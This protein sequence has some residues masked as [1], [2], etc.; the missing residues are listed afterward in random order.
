MHVFKLISSFAQQLDAYTDGIIMKGDIVLTYTI[1]KIR[2]SRITVS[3]KYQI[4]ISK[5]ITDDVI[6][7]NHTTHSIQFNFIY[8]YYR[9]ID[10]VMRQLNMSKGA[11]SQNNSDNLR[12]LPLAFFARVCVQI[13]IIL[14]KPVQ[15]HGRYT[16]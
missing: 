9:Q 15:S 3:C 2:R 14:K 16:K 1:R 4:S 11:Q 8:R 13:A 12:E 5:S 10:A 6:V 7:V